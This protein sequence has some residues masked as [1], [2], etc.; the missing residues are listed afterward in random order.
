MME[1]LFLDDKMSSPHKLYTE[2]A[3]NYKGPGRSIPIQIPQG[4]IVDL[5]SVLFGVLLWM[6]RSQVL[7]FDENIRTNKSSTGYCFSDYRAV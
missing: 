1:F 6:L 2:M 4:K 7:P 3:K 5:L